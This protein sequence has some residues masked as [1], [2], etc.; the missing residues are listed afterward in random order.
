MSAP[1]YVWSVDAAC[2]I[3]RIYYELGAAYDI[4]VVIL[5]VIRNDHNAVELRDT[6]QWRAG[7]IQSVFTAP[8]YRREKRI[9]VFHMG[10]TLL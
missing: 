1:D 8:A 10:S 7:H 2:R 4:R 5:G 3:T 9:I 6:V